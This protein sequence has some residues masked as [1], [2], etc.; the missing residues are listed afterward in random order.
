MKH[1]IIGFWA[2]VIFST[3]QFGIILAV[4]AIMVAHLAFIIIGTG[5]LAAY[6]SSWVAALFLVVAAILT[7]VITASDK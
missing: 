5:L 6:V 3:K 1:P 7:T 2:E 4:F